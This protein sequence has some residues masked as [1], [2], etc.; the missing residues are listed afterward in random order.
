MPQDC[1]HTPRLLLLFYHLFAGTPFPP[2]D[3]E[4]LQ[5]PSPFSAYSFFFWLLLPPCL[6]PCPAG[7][8]PGPNFHRF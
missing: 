1:M 8:V 2:A 6:G 3:P 4:S 7:A 5:T